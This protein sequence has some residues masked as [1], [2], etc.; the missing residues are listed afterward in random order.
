[1]N[2]VARELISEFNK[3]TNNKIWGNKGY[4]IDPYL[5]EHESVF[6]VLGETIKNIHKS[7]HHF[8]KADKK[9]LINL[10]LN[11]LSFERENKIENPYI[12]ENQDFF[13]ACTA[14]MA[15]GDMCVLENVLDDREPKEH[16]LNFREILNKEIG[17]LTSVSKKSIL[18]NGFS[19]E[20]TIDAAKLQNAK[21]RIGVSE[22]NSMFL[23]RNIY[24]F[25]HNKNKNENDYVS[26]LGFSVLGDR[27]FYYVKSLREEVGLLEDTDPSIRH[28]QNSQNIHEL[29]VFN[30]KIGNKSSNRFMDKPWGKYIMEKYKSDELYGPNITSSGINLA[31]NLV[32]SDKE[33]SVVIFS[34]KNRQRLDFIMKLMEYPIP[35]SNLI[36]MVNEEN[37]DQNKA[38]AYIVSEFLG[39]PI[40]NKSGNIKLSVKTKRFDVDY[41]LFK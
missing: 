38:T 19:C 22:C 5:P 34:S 33:E 12:R 25:F 6:D 14:S 18:M 21:L 20:T 30:F 4:H 16:I 24:G 17:V 3:K 9:M 11:A 7:R 29:D 15:L 10:P 2:S 23:L 32:I 31:L 28:F 36:K 8:S 40:V 26:D 39:T 41:H 35:P 1:M 37:N 13:L 27:C